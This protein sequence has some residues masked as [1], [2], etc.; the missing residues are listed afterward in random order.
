MKPRWNIR[1]AWFDDD[2][3]VMEGIADFPVHDEIDCPFVYALAVAEAIN[4][5]ND[6]A[7]AALAKGTGLYDRRVTT[8]LLVNGRRSR[9]ITVEDKGMGMPAR[10]AKEC[11]ETIM[12]WLTADETTE[13]LTASS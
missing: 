6:R 3:V 2:R 1:I 12:D 7:M 4:E 9:S 5:T 11:A 13:L 8:I 10:K